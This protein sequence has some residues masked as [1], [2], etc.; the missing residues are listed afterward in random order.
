[1]FNRHPQARKVCLQLLAKVFLDQRV[2]LCIAKVLRLLYSH[3]VRVQFFHN[4][5][6]VSSTPPSLARDHPFWGLQIPSVLV[7][8]AMQS[9]FARTTYLPRPLIVFDRAAAEANLALHVILLLVDR[10]GRS[11]AWA[12]GL[13][14][15]SDWA[16]SFPSET[17]RDAFG[18][19]T[20]MHMV[21]G[22]RHG[23]GCL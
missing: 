12:S 3:L 8:A 1:M 20:N 23:Q 18:V 10:R 5:A 17:D 16:D 2:K 15:A 7:A 4:K 6:N 11:R 22:R 21:A 19:S 9:I 13:N 14:I